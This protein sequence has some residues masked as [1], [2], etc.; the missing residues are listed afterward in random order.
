MPALAPAQTA[1]NLFDDSILHEIRLVMKPADWTS[2]KD[3][4]PSS[5]NWPADLHWTYQGKDVSVTNVAVQNHGHG[6]RSPV[7]PS[8]GIDMNKNVSGQR[9]LGLTS[10]VLKSNNQDSSTLHEPTV[11]KLW[12]RL[13]MPASRESSARVFVNTEYIGVYAIV[14]DINGQY[15][16]RY[17]GENNGDL[18]EW[19]PIGDRGFRWDWVPTCVDVY[20]IACSTDPKR[21][22]TIPFDPKQNKSTFNLAPTIDLFR[23]ATV[24]ADADLDKTMSGLIDPGLLL[25]HIANE[26]YVADFDT[27]LGDVFGMNNFWV[28][29]YEKSNMQQFLVWDKDGSFAWKDR[30]LF[31]NADQN[32]FMR[33]MLTMA[34]RRNQYLEALYRVSVI[35]GGPGG[36][37]EAEHNRRYNLIHQ[38]A[39]DDKNKLYLVA[40]VLQPSDNANFEAG[41]KLNQDF[42]T[43]RGPFLRQQVLNN[44]FTLPSNFKLSDGGALNAA[45]NAIG[46]AIAPGSDVSLY[47]SGFTDKNVSAS[48]TALPTVLGGVRVW[49][50]GFPAPLIFVGPSQINIQVPWEVGLGDGTTPF[51]VSIDGPTTKGTRANSPVNMTFGNTIAAP[52]K[53]YA[54]G[55]YVALQGDGKLP[56]DE[57]AGAGDILVVY[58]TGLGP[59]STPQTTGA[60]ASLTTLITT[61]QTPAVT[62]GGVPADI[63]FSGLTPG[64]AGVY[65]VNIRLRGGIPSGGAPLVVSIGG[66]S[67][68]PFN[69]PTR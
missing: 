53:T 13:G 36:W 38:A 40:G 59:V 21:W 42:I 46:G 18:Y 19:K 57:P 2:F 4:Y 45:S 65:Q 29:R 67:S 10:L 62:V 30:P 28:Y 51:T 12:E 34:S 7:K 43:F 14:E 68:A 8:I 27:I 26:V 5:L 23:M 35:S 41:I 44:G 61:T 66:E 52:V 48:G 32:T 63:L 1:D 15:L 54:P 49:V 47:G 31:Q 56:S 60:L 6:S 25:H 39:L 11:M 9:F 64:T 17:L 55:V 22:T 50:N 33:R 16:N 69:L 58:C 24:S 20:A 37:L 3:N